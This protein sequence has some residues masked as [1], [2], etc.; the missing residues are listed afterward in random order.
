VW[1]GEGGGVEEG[2]IVCGYASK[3]K[4]ISSGPGRKIPSLQVKQSS[5]FAG[6][7]RPELFQKRET[8][9]WDFFTDTLS[10]E[11]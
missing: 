4:L 3:A 9:A 8:K 5:Y 10:M 1:V 7:H 6:K 2:T 11:Y